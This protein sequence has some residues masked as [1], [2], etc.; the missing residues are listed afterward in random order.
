[1]LFAVD[2]RERAP[3][4]RALGVVAGQAQELESLGRRLSRSQRYMPHV[5]ASRPNSFSRCAEPPP[6]SPN[7][8]RVA[9]SRRGRS[10]AQLGQRAGGL[11][12]SRL[13]SGVCS[14]TSHIC[15]A[16]RASQASR[17]EPG[18]T[19]RVVFVS[20]VS[21]GA[22]D[23]CVDEDHGMSGYSPKPLASSFPWCARSELSYTSA[24]PGRSGCETT[25]P[26][27]L[28]RGRKVPLRD[29]L[30]GRRLAYGRSS[31]GSCSAQVTAAMLGN[32]AAQAADSRRAE[33]DVLRRVT[34]SSPTA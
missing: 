33:P 34:P 14:H 21:E 31:R 5:S 7:R 26:Q 19:A 15:W 30:A 25:S 16:A 8:G 17:D 23:V 3:F 22:Q 12:Y 28:Q 32:L 2:M 4:A 27:E 11:R 1:M 13:H 6:R 18:C 29:Q 24:R 10:P 20:A 9:A